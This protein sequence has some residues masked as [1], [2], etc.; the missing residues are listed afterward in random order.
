MIVPLQ[1][2]RIDYQIEGAKIVLYLAGIVYWF[3]A[4]VRNYD[5]TGSNPTLVRFKSSVSA[6]SEL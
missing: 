4:L 2:P 3:V 1:G 6:L 5:V